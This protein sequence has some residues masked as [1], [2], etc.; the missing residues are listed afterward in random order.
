MVMI[1]YDADGNVLWYDSL[2]LRT[3]RHDATITSPVVTEDFEGALCGVTATTQNQLGF[4]PNGDPT[5]TL[6]LND[7][8]N[9]AGMP[10]PCEIYT[11]TFVNAETGADVDP[12]CF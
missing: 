11:L 12:T 9:F 5:L 2:L 3:V 6:A 7:F 10:S 8:L 1:A 4:F